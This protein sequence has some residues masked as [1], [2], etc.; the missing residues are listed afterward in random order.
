MKKIFLALFL[1]CSIT[2]L[3][4]QDTDLTTFILVRHAE[5]SNDDP[6]NPNLSEVGKER[7]Q[8]LKE[9]LANTGVTAIYS[10][11]YKRTQ[12]TA[13]PLATNLGLEIQNYNPSSM[14]FL[15]GIWKEHKGGT[16]LISGH[17]NTTPFVANHL[18]GNKT[19]EMLD[20]KEYDK[21]FIVTGTASGKTKVT[22]LTY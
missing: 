9:L 11:P 13:Q 7:A 1:V 3:S 15:A 20:E 18:L 19:F 17:S 16:I 6:R 10:T 22:V 12:Q 21:V 5:K 8:A 2:S 14:D 4:A